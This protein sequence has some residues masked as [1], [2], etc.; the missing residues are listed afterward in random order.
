[1]EQSPSLVRAFF[2]RLF[3]CQNAFKRPLLISPVAPYG[4]SIVCSVAVAS[5]GIVRNT[6]EAPGSRSD[7]GLHD[8]LGTIGSACHERA[9]AN[10]GDSGLPINLHGIPAAFTAHHAGSGDFSLP[11]ETAVIQGVGR[12]TRTES[13][14]L[15]T[16]AAEATADV[17]ADPSRCGVTR[18]VAR[19]G[20][21]ISPVGRGSI[22]GCGP[23]P[24]RVICAET[25]LTNRNTQTN[26]TTNLMQHS[27][28]N[29]APR[30][31]ETRLVMGMFS[32][33]SRCQ[34]DK[35]IRKTVP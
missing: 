3:F 8:N 22:H 18:L 35:A 11:R 20:L 34:R 25:S 12:R 33:T 7:Q 28:W 31:Q 26:A 2:C 19:D 32:T 6:E 29:V 1:M 9:I 21:R 30:T 14:A 23:G 27:S 5:R 15:S 16:P 4:G 13:H 10:P 24:R 17:A